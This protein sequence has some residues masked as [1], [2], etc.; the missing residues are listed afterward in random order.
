[1]IAYTDF[2][3]LL[4]DTTECADLDAYI[5]KEVG[6][7]LTNGSDCVHIAPRSH[8]RPL[9]PG[10]AE[11]D[12]EDVTRVLGVIWAMGHEGL[13]IRSIASAAGLSMR[14][15][16]MTYS[17]PARTVENWACGLRNPPEW[18]L[19]LIAYAVLSDY[20]TE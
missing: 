2:R 3:R 9:L 11:D 14:R 1:M 16:A 18:Q 12:E 13:T 15:L 6:Q 17:L 5:A 8:S 20:R 10:M 19:P 7:D 4:T